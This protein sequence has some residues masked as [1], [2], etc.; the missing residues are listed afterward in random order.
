LN[1]VTELQFPS[2]FDS[3]KREIRINGEAYLH[4][5]K[6]VSRR[7][8]VHLPGNTVKVLGTEFNVNSY[9]ANLVKVSLVEGAVVLKSAR[10]SVNILPGL[11][12][13]STGG[14]INSQPF[15]AKKALG[16]RDGIFYFEKA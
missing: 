13:K 16:W 15:D 5:K 4:I 8:I 11:Q 10:D 9:S 6:D 14:S 2:A 7:F 3:L 12:A 1:S